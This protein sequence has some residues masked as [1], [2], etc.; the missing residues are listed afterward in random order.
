MTFSTIFFSV[1]TFFAGV[2]LGFIVASLVAFTKKM[3]EE[4]TASNEDKVQ[5]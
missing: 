1:A 5:K 3:E 2:V 4:D